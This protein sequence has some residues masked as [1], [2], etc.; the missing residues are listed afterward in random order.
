[1]LKLDY[2]YMIVYKRLPILPW[3][4]YFVN[5]NP[6]HRF[7]KKSCQFYYLLQTDSELSSF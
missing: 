6:I 2:Y 5:H 3:Q 4:V 1:M 7:Y